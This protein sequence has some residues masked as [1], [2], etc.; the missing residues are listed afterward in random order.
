MPI[1]PH[2]LQT[3]RLILR[4]TSAA[5]AG[6]VIEIH[7]DWEVTRMLASASFPPDVQEIERWFADHPCEWMMGRAYRFAVLLDDRMVGLV[8]IDGSTPTKAAWAIGWT[9]PCG[10]ADMLLRPRTR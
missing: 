3:E 4:P 7:G 2:P 9:A 1:P 8:D 6:R 10:D 5:D